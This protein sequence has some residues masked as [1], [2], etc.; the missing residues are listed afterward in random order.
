MKN[1]AKYTVISIFILMLYTACPHNKRAYPDI[2][3]GSQDSV[4]SAPYVEGGISLVVSKHKKTIELTVKAS[5]SSNIVLEGA[6]KSNITSN[7]TDTVTVNGRVLI[8]KPATGGQLT[9]FTCIDQKIMR[10]NASGC[11]TLTSLTCNKNLLDTLKVHTEA[12]LTHVT[13]TE[14]RLTDFDTQSCKEL[15]SLE[16]GKNNLTSLNLTNLTHLRKANCRENPRLTQLTVTGCINLEDLDCSGS[17][18]TALTAD[19]LSKLKELD[20]SKNNLSQLTVTGCSVLENLKCSQN[21]LQTLD[22][23]NLPKL[24]TLNC[25]SNELTQLNVQNCPELSSINC[26]DNKLPNLNASNLTKLQTLLCDTNELTGIDISGAAAVLHEIECYNNKLDAQAVKTLLNALPDR[27]SAVTEGKIVLCKK[28]G[29]TGNITDFTQP[30][31]LLAA[32]NT[33]KG[34]K[35]KLYKKTDTE[36]GEEI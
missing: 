17:K 4:P 21:K 36:P 10:I 14:N 9:E 27:T 6:D 11:K 19:N 16:C 28:E 32:V 7:N 33:A 23:G 30:A 15:V 25:S 2:T 18:L 22:A 1:I 24:D 20:C 35:W 26:Y 3:S 31:D 34:H 29:E 8:I 13:C 5:G 12:K